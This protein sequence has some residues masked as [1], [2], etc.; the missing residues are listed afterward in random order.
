M[1]AGIGLPGGAR[2]LA[3][4][5]IV[6]K[7]TRHGMPFRHVMPH[8]RMIHL[9]MIHFRMIH[10]LSRLF[11]HWLGLRRGRWHGHGHLMPGV[12]SGGW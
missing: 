11:G 5:R 4:H 7:G 3:G 12:L 2:G 1:F 6:A 9:G 10:G 8:G